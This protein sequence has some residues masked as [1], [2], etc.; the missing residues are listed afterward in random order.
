MLRL[1]FPFRRHKNAVEA[2]QSEDPRDMARRMNDCK[3]VARMASV[4]VERNK[5]SQ[6]SSIDALDG[7]NVEE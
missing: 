4:T 2:N 3:F 6:S 7:S 1:V 5:S